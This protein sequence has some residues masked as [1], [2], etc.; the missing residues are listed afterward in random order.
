MSIVEN[1]DTPTK[2]GRKELKFVQ[3]LMASTLAVEVGMGLNI[4]FN[5][6]IGIVAD[7]FLL[8]ASIGVALRVRDE[9]FHA[10]LWSPAVSWF[11]AM[12]TVGEFSTNSGG[13]WVAQQVFLLVYGLGSHFL[14]I[15]AATASAVVV[16]YLRMRKV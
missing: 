15:L 9:D 8:I 10:T 13:S 16:R 2:S 7:L 12:I 1:L 14:W 3:V 11:I 4:A 6:S 5:H